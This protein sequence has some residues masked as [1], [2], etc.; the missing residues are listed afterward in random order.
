MKDAGWLKIGGEG[1]YV[2][3]IVFQKVFDVPEE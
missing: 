2:D 1:K 3:A